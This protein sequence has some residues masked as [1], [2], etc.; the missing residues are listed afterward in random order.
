LEVDL[1]TKLGKKMI[2]YKLFL[3]WWLLMVAVVMATVFS[4]KS[5]V[6]YDI[7]LKDNSYLS[8]VILALFYTMT[9]WCGNKTWR[10]SK[11]VTGEVEYTNAVKEELTRLEE[12]G[13]FFSEQCLTLG[14][15]GTVWGF[16]TMLPGF[17]LVNAGDTGSIQ[18]LLKSLGGG[19]STALYTTLVGLICGMLLKLQYFNISHAIET[20]PLVKKK[21]KHNFVS[22]AGHEVEVQNDN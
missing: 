18:N 3:K 21:C 5:G 9:I 2:K 6:F 16:V 1:L 13:W 12:I 11:I 10:V 4:Y 15:I 19:M 20:S 17:S 14:M 7:W 22:C 8:F